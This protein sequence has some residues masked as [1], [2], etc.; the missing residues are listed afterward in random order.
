MAEGTAALAGRAALA[1]NFPE[2]KPMRW[3]SR[4]SCPNV[5]SSK[6]G[7][8]SSLPVNTPPQKLAGFLPEEFQV[9]EAAAGYRLIN[10][11]ITT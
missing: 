2:A 3:R 11:D 10:L 5:S 4:S 7:D 1:T 9:C 6:R 8:G